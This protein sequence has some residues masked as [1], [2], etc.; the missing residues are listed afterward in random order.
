MILR[1][2]PIDPPG[3][4]FGTASSRLLFGAAGTDEHSNTYG[5]K[6][7]G[8]T[9]LRWNGGTQ[10]AQYEALFVNPYTLW[11]QWATDWGGSCSGFDY[12]PA[13][14]T[15]LL[16]GQ[17]APGNMHSAVL[18]APYTFSHDVTGQGAGDTWH[19]W[20]G[21][22]WA[23]YAWP[24][25]CAPIPAPS[26]EGLWNSLLMAHVCPVVTC[27][28]HS[29]ATS[30]LQSG[31]NFLVTFLYSPQYGTYSFWYGGGP[32]REPFIFAA[33]LYHAEFDAGSGTWVGTWYWWGGT[34]PPAWQSGVPSWR[35]WA[36]GDWQNGGGPLRQQYTRTLRLRSGQARRGRGTRRSRTRSRTLLW[37][38]QALDLDAL[39]LPGVTCRTGRP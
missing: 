37:Q 31:S 39:V 8:T 14:Q 32:P 1:R 23:S 38:P 24:P 6:F 15:G 22:A 36:Q 4:F 3:T 26:N 20:N 21:A 13:S 9:C 34:A 5:L 35:Y 10:Y 28:P 12:D 18:L 17:W 16:V 30:G 29:E 33:A 25:G 19:M 7:D 2:D 27:I 11:G